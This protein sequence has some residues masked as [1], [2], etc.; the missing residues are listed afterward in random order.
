MANPWIEHVKQYAKDKKISY[1][2]ALKKA[3]ATYKPKPKK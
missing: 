2:E 3:K 1:T